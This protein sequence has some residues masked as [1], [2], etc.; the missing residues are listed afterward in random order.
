MWPTPPRSAPSWSPRSKKRA[1]PPAGW[2]WALPSECGRKLRA[3][4]HGHCPAR[5]AAGV[6]CASRHTPARRS[7]A[8]RCSRRSGY[9]GRCSPRSN[10]LADH[11]RRD[12]VARV[13][14]W[15]GHEGVDVNQLN[16][17][18]VTQCAYSGAAR[19]GKVLKVCSIKRLGDTESSVTALLRMRMFSA[20]VTCACV[21]STWPTAGGDGS[22]AADEE[23]V[24]RGML[25]AHMGEGRMH[26]G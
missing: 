22:A 12:D 23:Y 13:H 3:T 17:A 1:L 6:A 10:L 7:R 9:P 8:R 16:E 19:C 21:P 20:I 5:Q 25:L 24:L 26:A 2:C 11:Y 14:P 4:A 18:C 15:P